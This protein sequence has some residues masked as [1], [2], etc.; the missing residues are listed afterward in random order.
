MERPSA[1]MVLIFIIIVAAVIV[2]ILGFAMTKPNTLWVQRSTS[3]NAPPETIFDLINDFHNWSI[4]APHDNMDP[5][6]KRTYSG[7]ATGKGAVSDWVSNGRA[8]RGRM[9][10]VESV[11]TSKIS[12]LVDF[13]KPFETHNLNEFNLEPAGNSTNVTWT[14]EGMNLYPMKLMSIFVDMESMFGKHFET[15]LSSL[16][17]VAER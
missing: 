1:L 2:A 10:I 5:T 16:K 11:P 13:V 9:A 6:M 12:I 15:G 7:P 4:W 3:I 14:M 17:I 8:G